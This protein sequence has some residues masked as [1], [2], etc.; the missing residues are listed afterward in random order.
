MDKEN[1][2]DTWRDDNSI[3]RA[4]MSHTDKKAG[5][6]GVAGGQNYETSSLSQ[7]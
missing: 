2:I 7:I 4:D 5:T 1:K 3:P 6:S